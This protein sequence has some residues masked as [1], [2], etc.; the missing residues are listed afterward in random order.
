VSGAPSPGS[1][2]SPAALAAVPRRA[3]SFPATVLP[4]GP[5]SAP[6]P[7]PCPVRTAP[8]WLAPGSRSRRCPGLRSAW[9]SP[10]RGSP[11]PEPAA[12]WYGPVLPP[13]GVPLASGS[14]GKPCSKIIS[15]FRAV[16]WRPRS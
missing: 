15:G 4:A 7:H 13:L 3:A 11:C 1:A 9:R 16:A 8:C 12:A 10:R 5:R 2:P 6:E 14:D